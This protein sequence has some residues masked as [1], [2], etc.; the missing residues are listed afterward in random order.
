MLASNVFHF[1]PVI[2][3]DGAALVESVWKS[4]KKIINKRKN[5]NPNYLG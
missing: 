4:D 5:N 1:I 3:A 2:N